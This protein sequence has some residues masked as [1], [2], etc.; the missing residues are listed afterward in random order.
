MASTMNKMPKTLQI[1]ANQAAVA[2]QSNQGQTKVKP[3]T[4]R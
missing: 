3:G 4:V 2:I 1:F